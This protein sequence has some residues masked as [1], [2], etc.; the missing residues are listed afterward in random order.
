V[1]GAGGVGGAGQ[2]GFSTGGQMSSGVSAISRGG[3][4]EAQPA[5]AS[6]SAAPAMRAIEDNDAMAWVF[7]EIFVALAIAVAIVWWTVP[8]KPKSPDKRE[9]KR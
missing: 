2:T 1:T 3:G 9:E 4:G 7:L 5:I 6:T 8:R